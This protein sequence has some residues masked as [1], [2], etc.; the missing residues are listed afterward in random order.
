VIESL[1]ARRM[2]LGDSFVAVRSLGE[3]LGTGE[4]T[5]PDGPVLVLRV[6]QHRVALQVDAVVAQEEVVVKSLKEL[7]QEHPV[8]ASV[9]VRNG[10]LV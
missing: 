3:V 4:R 9:T 8:L 6:G 5:R 7:L 1:G 10:K 2:R